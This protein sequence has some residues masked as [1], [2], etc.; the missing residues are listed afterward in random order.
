MLKNLWNMLLQHRN[1]NVNQEWNG[2]GFRCNFHPV[3]TL[4]TSCHLNNRQQLLKYS[5]DFGF[6]ANLIKCYR[7]CV[8]CNKLFLMMLIPVS[9]L[10]L[11]VLYTIY[12]QNLVILLKNINGE[13]KVGFVFSCINYHF[14]NT[15]K[16]KWHPLHCL[17]TVY[18]QL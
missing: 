1:V 2:H 14:I 17:F 9:L 10:V 18:T 13:G 8:S 12:R 5:L 11:S 16:H 6:D 3:I 15:S 4:P 7:L